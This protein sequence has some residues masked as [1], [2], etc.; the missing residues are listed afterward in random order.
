VNVE[1]VRT[2]AHCLG[3]D[4]GRKQ[5]EQVSVDNP[6]THIGDEGVLREYNRSDV[7]RLQEYLETLEQIDPEPLTKHHFA[8]GIYVR[9]L[10]IPAGTVLTGK[11]HRHETMNILVSGTLKVTTDDG[12]QELTGPMIFN[13]QPG[14]K[15][16]AVT[17]TDVIW[18]NVHP[19]ESTDLEEIEQEF[20]VPEDEALEQEKRKCLGGT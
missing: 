16:A 17:F 14:M 11:V 13:S 12:V 1:P 8:P 6:V 7:F 18:L 9:E 20:I 3:R 4:H 19:T 5:L 15:K 2:T 10:L